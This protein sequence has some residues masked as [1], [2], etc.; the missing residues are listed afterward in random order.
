MSEA[1]PPPAATIVTFDPLQGESILPLS[2]SSR[3]AR[4][5]KFH[6]A[7][8][9]HNHTVSLDVISDLAFQGIPEDVKGIRPVYWKVTVLFSPCFMRYTSYF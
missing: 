6:E 8:H 1:Q 9:P 7:I 4:I 2:T 3:A 5:A